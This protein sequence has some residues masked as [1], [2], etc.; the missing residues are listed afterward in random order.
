[1]KIIPNPDKL[2]KITYKHTNLQSNDNC[3]RINAM[4]LGSIFRDPGQCALY[5]IL[6]LQKENNEIKINYVY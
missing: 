1:M 2:T 5:L 4:S 6:Q 3:K